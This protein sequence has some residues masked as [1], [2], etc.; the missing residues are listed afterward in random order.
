MTSSVSYEGSPTLITSPQEIISNAY[1]LI[2]QVGVQN[3]SAAGASSAAALSLF[4]MLSYSDLS[5]NNWRFNTK[6][7]QLSQVANF[8]PNY[9]SYTAAYYCPP[10]MIALRNLYPGTL[11]Y[12]IYGNQIWTSTYDTLSAEY[13]A[14]VP[15]SLWPAYYSNYFTYKLAENLA[16]SIASNIGMFKAITQLKLEA[17][18]IAMAVDAQNR[19]QQAFQNFPSLMNRFSNGPT[20]WNYNAY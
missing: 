5:S 8:N 3:S 18:A 2:N 17:A 12:Q 10:D 15:V 7:Q 9:Q 13:R 20:L 1:A 19:P 16:A 4:N 11:N 6:V 14:W